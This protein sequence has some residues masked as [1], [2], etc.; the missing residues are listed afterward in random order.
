MTELDERLESPCIRRCTLDVADVCIG[1]GRSLDDIKRWTLVSPG[2]QQR[3]LD[4][5]RH[6]LLKARHY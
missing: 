6:C 3:I 2:E 1:C 4:R 5:A